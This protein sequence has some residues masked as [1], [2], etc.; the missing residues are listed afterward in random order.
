[1]SE[2]FINFMDSLFD[3]ETENNDYSNLDYIA[4]G[5]K[6]H[7]KNGHI[8]ETFIDCDNSPTLL[9]T[10]MSIYEFSELALEE[11][12][13]AFET[14]D[15]I[16]MIVNLDH[17]SAIELPMAKIEDAICSTLVEHIRE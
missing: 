15:N 11:K 14:D 5:I 3:T 16:E 9:S 4:N 6:L 13:I 8:L 17:I 1:M 12:T 7:Y 2:K 10:I